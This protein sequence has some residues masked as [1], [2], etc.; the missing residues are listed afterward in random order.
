MRRPWVT[1]PS[2]EA[3]INLIVEARKSAGL[4]QRELADRLGKP[5]SFVSKLENRERRLDVVEFVALT[6]ALGVEP[7]DMMSS[8]AATLPGELDF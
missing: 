5:R 2:Y 6:R 1:S 3:A 4:S 7:A 8:L